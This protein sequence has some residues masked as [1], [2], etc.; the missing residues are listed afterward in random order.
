MSLM[1]TDF[2]A[3][4]RKTQK[5][6]EKLG[7]VLHPWV[8]DPDCGD[9]IS[10]SCCVRCFMGARSEPMH[11]DCGGISG[12][13]TAETCVPKILMSGR[14][15]VCSCEGL[16][17][18]WLSERR[19]EREAEK[20]VIRA[21]MASAQTTRTLGRATGG[22]SYAVDTAE[23][24]AI[25][26]SIRKVKVPGKRVSR[27]IVDEVAWYRHVRETERRLAWAKK[28]SSPGVFVARGGDLHA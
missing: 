22:G 6:A 16:Y 12:A 27:L 20:L 2:Q 21:C 1:G 17:R 4:Q 7:H 15:I 19:H 11:G 25:D 18:E 14:Q 13:A 3:F 26:G 8:D 28:H 24:L 5:R 10:R 23:S 9:F